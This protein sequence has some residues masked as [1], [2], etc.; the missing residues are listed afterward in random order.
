MLVQ[1]FEIRTAHV[2][3]PLMGVM[4]QLV[5]DGLNKRGGLDD[6]RE[7]VGPSFEVDASLTILLAL[8]LAPLARVGHE[9]RSV[10]VF[11]GEVLVGTNPGRKPPAVLWRCLDLGSFIHGR[12]VAIGASNWLAHRRAVGSVAERLR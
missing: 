1:S 10:Q 6:S 9:F 5:D 4:P 3:T 11:T 2:G 8:L 12:I 7:C